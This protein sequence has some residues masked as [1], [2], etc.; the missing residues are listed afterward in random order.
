[1]NRAFR[2][3]IVLLALCISGL[4][5]SAYYG[6]YGKSKQKQFYF[7]KLDYL[8][9]E[10]R[11]SSLYREQERI[12][13]SINEHQNS[14]YFS[15]GLVIR[16]SS[17]IIHKNFLVLDLDAAY[18]PE[19]NKDNFLVIPDQSEV[20][21]TKKL[22]L[23]ASFFKE[24]DFNLSLFGNYDESYST[25]ENLT[26]IRTNNQHLGASM[27]YNNLF[28][29][30]RLDVHQRFWNEEEIGG[31]RSYKFDQ[32]SVGATF[33]KSF[34]QS[35][36]S[37]L[38]LNHDRNISI[39]Q[40]QFRIANTLN[41]LDFHNSI[42]LDKGQRY[43]LIT[44]VNGIDQ[45]GN[46]NMR[47]IQAME[48]LN[49]KLSE[50]LNFLTNY[51]FQSTRQDSARLK[52]N[53]FSTTLQH[54]LF[55]SL[56]TS[57]HFD[58]D[59]LK[60]TAF[61]EVNR[62]TGIELN[63]TKKIPGGHLNIVYKLDTYRQD[64]TS[65]SID[66]RTLGEEYTLSDNRITLLKLPYIILS[67]VVVRDISGTLIY[68]AGLDYMLIQQNTFIEIRRIPGGAIPNEGIVLVDYTATRP[69]D[70]R[71]DAITN[72][73]NVNLYLFK[74]HL[75]V[76]YRFSNQDYFGLHTTDF[77]TL[78]YFTQNMAGLRL[79]LGVV[80]LGAE[81]EDYQS[82]ILPYRMTRYYVN[83]QQNLGERLI[84]LLNGNLQDYVM[85]NDDE[86]RNQ[87]YIDVSGK[88]SY[89]VFRQTNLNMD[90]MYRNQSGR[91][92]DLDLFTGRAEVTSTINRL[93]LAGGVEVYR[94]NYIGEKI[95]FKGAYIKLI[96]KF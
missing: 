72:A 39:N 88:V 8:T 81:H 92:I 49:F 32:F 41:T 84:L 54:T 6:K 89:N 38:R 12:G 83:Y 62:K 43:N 20:R 51:T 48:L 45:F 55:S 36:R 9:G 28:V 24:K 73:V 66:L 25:R 16:S 85:L 82:S 64:H 23:T 33:N 2:H 68:E 26:N 44:S 7:C 95:N 86:S 56:R 63:Y 46:L 18:L 17:S 60:H 58:Y 76:Y 80:S 1:M 52:Q 30:F 37:E 79:D 11:F 4:H 91:G 71:Y 75:S 22:D 5:A 19:S 77:V 34:R 42:H 10:V 69:G 21:S 90:I 40:Y 14:K 67:S 74:N 70:Y 96:R 3:I 53:G 15:G 87:R 59:R 29:P 13:I 61:R 94:R 57:I 31:S 27:G 35:D 50:N 65:G 78:N 47:R 93:Y